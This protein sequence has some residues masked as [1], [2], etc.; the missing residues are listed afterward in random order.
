L[1]TTPAAAACP[2]AAA[3]AVTRLA[4][5]AAPSAA[6]ESAITASTIALAAMPIA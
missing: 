2:S 4:G 3:L 5:N 1:K 6:G